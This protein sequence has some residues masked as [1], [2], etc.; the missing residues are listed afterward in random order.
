MRKIIVAVLSLSLLASCQESTEM[1]SSGIT[2]PPVEIGEMAA[3]PDAKPMLPKYKTLSERFPNKADQ[4]GDFKNAHPEWFGITTAPS[5]AVR[6]AAEWETAQRLMITYSSTTLPAGIKQNLVDI[7]KYGKPVVSIYVIHGTANA[8]SNFQTLLQNAGVSATG[9]NFVQM[10][11]DSIWVRDCGPVSILT[12]TGSKVAFADFR[13]Y[14]ERIYDDA[15]P[16]KLAT[17]W[18]VSD[19][20]VPLDFEGGNFMSDTKGN[21]FASQGILWYNGVGEATVKQYLKDY[22][23]CTNSYFTTPL[24]GEGTT[25]IDMAHK[26]VS[27][28]G[29]VVGKYTA[30]QDAANKTILDNNAA[31]F[32]SLG[33]TV[34]RMPM[35]NNKDGNFRTYINSLFVNGVNMVPTYSVDKSLETEAMAVWKQAMPT[36]SHVA[37]NSDDVIKWAGA[38]HCITMTVVSGALQK[39]DAN[40][41]YVC[42]GN[43]WDCYP[44]QASGCGGVSFEGCC[45]GQ[46]L[47]YCENNQLKTMNCGNQPQC[48]WDAQGKFYNCGTA[49]GAD[50]SGQFPKACSGTCTPSCAGK[51]C[52]DDGC[53]G[54]CGTCPAGQTCNAGQC[55]PQSCTPVCTGKQC[56]DDGCGGSCGTCP[57]GQQCQ[58]GKCVQ[59]QDPCQG[60]SW[61]GCCD[62]QTLKYCEENQ[63]KT[64]N[65]GNQPQ[66]GW[67]AQG[68]FYNCGTA[69]AADPS[70]L[71]PKECKGSCAPNCTGKQCG[72]DGCGGSCGICQAGLSCSPQGKC[73]QSCVPNCTGKQC[74]D[75]GCGGSCGSCPVGQQCQAGKCQAVQDPCL[76]ISWEGC[77]EGTILHY[78][79]NGQLVSGECGPAGCG[80][81]PGKLYY[82]CQFQGADP[83]GAHPLACPGSSC[84]PNCGGKQCGDD[85]CGGSCG[86]CA[87][88]QFC[89]QGKC[90][91]QDPCGNLTYQG[92]CEGNTLKWCQDNKPMSFDCTLLGP[93]FICAFEN[94]QV[95]NNC[96]EKSACTPSCN[97]KECGDDG[98]GG[99]CGKCADGFTCQAG[100]CSQ[101]PCTPSC[102][103]KECGDNGCGGSCG[104]CPGGW[105]CEN[106]H[107]N[108]SCVPACA[109]KQCGDD[110]CGGKCGTCAA[111]QSCVAGVCKQG[112]CTPD[113]TG[114]VCGDDGCGGSCGSCGNAEKCENGKCVAVC[115]PACAGKDCGPDGC[116]SSCG[117]CPAG[118][119]CD[120]AGKCKTGCTADCTGK[121]CGDD[122][123]GGLCG[124][125]PEGQVCVDGKCSDT[126]LPNCVGKNCGPDGCGGSCGNCPKDFTCDGG[127]CVANPAGC[128]DVTTAGL[129]VGSVLKKCASGTVVE[130]DCAGT[131][132]VCSFIPTSGMYDCVDTC[133]PLCAGKQCGDDG[134]GGTCGT[135]AKGFECDYSFK[136]VAIEQ[137]CVPQCTGKACGDDGCGGTCG[138]CADGLDCSNGACVEGP[139]PGSCADGYTWEAD[140]CVAAEQPGDGGSSDSSCTLSGPGSPTSAILLAALL[141]GLFSAS[142]TA[143]SRKRG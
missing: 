60:V 143:V 67:D 123:C 133:Q 104:S 142:R 12:Q 14:H 77:C 111:G 30:A 6:P 117:V 70:G 106:G 5:A 39:I 98:C 13:Y 108:T 24:D 53:G 73:V 131:G 134:C 48:G 56:G 115:Q 87:A 51:Q 99:T 88:G 41:G 36:W 86:T 9:V 28:S 107:C 37:M 33:Y 127:V 122:G 38:I 18:N 10:D 93:T 116:G 101:D 46:T 19:Y 40:P 58:A 138:E 89:Y 52:G 110:G 63:L 102:T 126:C 66:C 105:F 7:V 75:D 17:Q 81:N 55:K 61:E 129:C 139:G 20:R 43:G 32:E 47:K 136:C 34:Y 27:D 3:D 112:T 141:L 85:G 59:G 118:F 42:P 95:G 103:N 50:P 16:A 68:K 132:K 130:V 125:C 80:W 11:N 8:K 83:T 79:E 71:S 82:D 74:G 69:G 100:K 57:A 25:H 2:K 72:S 26:L 54:S 49:G 31:F 92:V 64:I 4:Y 84:I 97:G 65:C 119:S 121:L 35:A 113:C 78:C 109:D 140:A 76:G 135:C 137:P 1:R 128:G 29:V 45:D 22:L 96:I 62:G 15:I 114:N 124:S 91:A 90:Q 23:G 21:C 120:N 44:G 94:D